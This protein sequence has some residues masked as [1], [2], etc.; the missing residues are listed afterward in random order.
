MKDL[1]LSSKFLDTSP[2]SI[3]YE[4]VHSWEHFL[5]TVIRKSDIFY[6]Y[7]A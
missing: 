4:K 7:R 2:P 1:F 6:L 5:L 3:I